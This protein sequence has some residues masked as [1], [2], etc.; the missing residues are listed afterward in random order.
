MTTIVKLL[1]WFLPAALLLRGNGL[2]AGEP[3]LNQRHWVAP[4]TGIHHWA[5]RRNDGIYL[6]FS[7]RLPEQTRAFFQA[8]GFTPDAAERLAEICVIQTV[9]R[10]NSRTAVIRTDIGNWRVMTG[11]GERPYR[12]ESEW[13]K[14]WQSSNVSQAA[15]I[16]FRFA[17]LPASQSL[18]PGDW[19]QGMT[20]LDVPLGQR[21]DLRVRWTEDQATR[22]ATVAG[23][24][25][26]GDRTLHEEER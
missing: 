18:N 16:A 26:A 25:C 14:Q 24:R 4:G 17:L 19:L 7:Q 6:E 13:Q 1:S 23:V 2:A 8:R 20:T 12:L 22:E 11:T 5:V 3:L 15:R 10:N 21:F 9:I